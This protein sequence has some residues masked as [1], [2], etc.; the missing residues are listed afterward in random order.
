MP[1]LRVKETIFVGER[2][3]KR[4]ELVNAADPVVKGREQ[5]FEDPND[6]EVPVIE[7]ATAAPGEKRAVKS[8]GPLTTASLPRRKSRRST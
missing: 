8:T 2:A 1:T 3:L 6:V 5:F 4:G 7:Q